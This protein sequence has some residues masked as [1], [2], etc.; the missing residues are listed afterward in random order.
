MYQS[1]LTI[2]ILIILSFFQNKILAY[3]ITEANA[4]TTLEFKN[5]VGNFENIHPKVLYFKEGWNGYRYWMSYTPYPWGDTN[6]ENPCIAVSQDGYSWTVPDGLTN[7]LALCPEN[8]YNS[9][10]HLVYDKKN[11]CLEIWW[12]PYDI[13]SH[14]ENILRRVTYDGIHWSDSE[15]IM[16]RGEKDEMRLSPTVWKEGDIYTM[17]YSDGSVI[18][19]RELD[20][21]KAK[22]TW[23][24]PVTLPIEWNGLRGWH[25]DAIMD[26]DGNLEL[27]INAI[28]PGWTNNETDL[29]YVK[30]NAEMTSATPL[31]LILKR[32]NDIND[33]DHRS[34]YRS[35]LVTVGN[36]YRLYYSCI[37]ENW[38]RH[39]AMAEGPS[40][41]ALI[42][43][44]KETMAPDLIINELMQ[45]NIDCITD[46]LN[47][48]PDSWVEI[49]NPGDF[50]RNLGNYKIGTNKKSEKAYQLPDINVSPHSYLIIYCDKEGKEL[51]TD[52]RLDSGKENVYLFKN[53]E[54]ADMIEG[55][56][57]QPSPNIAYGRENDAENVWGYQL[58]PSPGKPNS[59]G[60]S[61]IILGDPVFTREG[62]VTNETFF[63]RL[64]IPKGAPEG[65]V[66][67]FTLD[68]KEPD[69]SSRT[70]SDLQPIK[71]EKST[72]VRAKLF[73]KGA[74]SPRSITHSYIFHPREM[75]IPII[76]IATNPEFLYGDELGILSSSTD[77]AGKPNYQKNWRR[78]V[79]FEFFENE[80]DPAVLNQLCETGLKGKT[81]RHFILKSMVFYANK[82]F[83]TKR[84]NHEF[85]PD[86]LPGITDFKSIETRNGGNDAYS[87]NMR[88]A[89]CQRM[90]GENTDID[91]Q[92]WRPAVV[93]INGEYHGI[94]NIRER[95]NEDNIYT[96]Y[97]GLEDVDVIENWVTVNEGTIDNFAKFKKFYSE[98]GHSLEEYEQWMDIDEFINYFIANMYF[99][100][101]DYLG[102]N[103]IM[104]R[105]IAEGGKWRWIC[106]DM[107]LAIGLDGATDP[108]F[109]YIAWIY[110][111]DLYPNFSF[112]NKP[113]YSL[114]F[115]RL[116]EIPEFLD[117][118]VDTF[119]IYTGDFLTDTE[120]IKKMIG[121][122]EVFKEEWPTHYEKNTPHWGDYEIFI[123]KAK[124]FLRSRHNMIHQQLADWYDLGTTIPVSVFDYKDLTSTIYL[125]DIPLRTG[126][127]EGKYI[128][129][130]NL[131]ISAEGTSDF[132]GWI[133][134]IVK[135]SISDFRHI[136]SHEFDFTVP[137][138]DNIKIYAADMD[139]FNGID[140]VIDNENVEGWVYFTISGLRAT[141]PHKLSPGIYIRTNGVTTEKV[142]VGK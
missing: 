78:P 113:E 29:Y 57:A 63:L 22:P 90:I 50:A 116:L 137:E 17:L 59:G 11:D 6:A 111:P 84:F 31:K 4:K 39:M 102:N 117:K 100:N 74:I 118:F 88:D 75:T 70:Y 18:K 136:Y 140:N 129:G 51:H 67:K 15:E 61:S 9:D 80:N 54:I 76:S 142:I 16:G 28:E 7:P 58:E 21:S 122:Y 42:G 14:T 94:L 134:E 48:F 38:H 45:S 77:L 44:T 104:W 98:E 40:P 114:L 10:S 73:C 68:G 95:S 32:G 36:T 125:Q 34:I 119:F 99:L 110:N 62:C 131:K 8:G 105:P 107:D 72:V 12:R 65:T 64:R 37:D 66:I 53:G 93:Y 13:T 128:S 5:Y 138:A 79:N 92:A 130:R 127:F 35:S 81:T 47:E 3:D 135:D 20:I 25:H 123:N 33:F 132:C 141:N 46:N 91:W 89:L 82:R 121:M 96:H 101:Y 2:L 1:L 55:I 52:F 43:A 108:L 60:I 86:Q 97:D 85:F 83:G 27:V 71:I 24:A 103:T 69:T 30:L 23:S 120:T 109:N 139:K 56:K 112:A 115:R 126:K 26:K 41:L 133:V 106:K 49:Y 19:K 87:L 124:V